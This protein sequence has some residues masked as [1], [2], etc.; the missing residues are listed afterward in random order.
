MTALDEQNRP[1]ARD[2][3]RTLAALADTAPVA[4]GPS[5]PATRLVAGKQSPGATDHTHVNPAHVRNQDPLE[6][7]L[8]VDAPSW[9]ARL[10]HSP[11]S[12]QPRSPSPAVP[13]LRTPTGTR[14][15]LP[16]P[17]P[18]HLRLPAPQG[19]GRSPHAP[20]QRDSPTTPPPS[21]HE[22]R[23]TAGSASPPLRP[24]R[25]ANRLTARIQ[26]AR[27]PPRHPPR[28]RHPRHQRHRLHRLHRATEV[29]RRQHRRPPRPRPPHNRPARQRRRKRL[30]AA[31]S[32]NRT[33]PRLTTKRCQR[34]GIRAA[35]ANVEI[36][37][38]GPVTPPRLG[39]RMDRVE[40]T[41]ARLPVKRLRSA[42]KSPRAPTTR[43]DRGVLRRI[44]RG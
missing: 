42:V 32:R 38:S 31:L 23:R 44:R 41:G 12:W 8:H 36:G 37:R 6:A 29:P 7:R 16:A 9:P 20:R 33:S 39:E 2:C 27:L 11:Q 3:A 43:P 13:P 19:S 21:A 34:I 24:V 5:R 18:V 1:T 30:G 40:V 26:R 10:S 4:A 35:A 28:A 25:W 15:G 14:R 22:R 17:P